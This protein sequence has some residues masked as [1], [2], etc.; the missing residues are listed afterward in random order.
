MRRF[1]SCRRRV[2]FFNAR[3]MESFAVWSCI[4]FRRVCAGLLGY[5]IGKVTV[6]VSINSDQSHHKLSDTCKCG[7]PAAITSEA[8]CSNTLATYLRYS[9]GICRMMHAVNI[10]GQF[11]TNCPV[12]ELT[13]VSSLS[14]D[15]L[16]L[17]HSYSML[18]QH[19]AWLQGC[20]H[21]TL[22]ICPPFL[23]KL[24]TTS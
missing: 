17:Q 18:T 12:T 2:S 22:C 19:A 15:R 23:P 1:K 10:F 8:Y 6:K 21:G 11:V 16:L 7:P 9:R 24:K 4:W 3:H 13:S 20:L 5:S 14:S